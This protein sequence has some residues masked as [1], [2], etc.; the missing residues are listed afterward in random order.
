[1]EENNENDRVVVIESLQNEIKYLK[2][3]NETLL[4]NK[5]AELVSGQPEGPHSVDIS[6]SVSTVVS[7][8]ENKKLEELRAKAGIKKSFIDDKVK[9]LLKKIKSFKTPKDMSN[10][11]VRFAIKESRTWEK[12]FDDIVFEQQKYYEECVAFNDLEEAKEQVR[13]EIESLEDA[14]SDKVS[15]LNTE[16]E[17]RGLSCRA[18]NRS[19]D[20]VVFPAVFRGDLGDNVYKFVEEIK[21]AII[22]SQIKKSDQVKTLIKYLGGEAKKRCGDHYADLESALNAL[23]EFYGNAALIWMKTRNEFDNAFTNL[24]KEW[25]EYGDPA[26]VTA[27]ARVIE[28][29]RQS[30]YLAKEY[31]ELSAEIYSSSTLTLLRKVLP[32]DYIEKVNDT[33]SDVSASSEQKMSKIKEFL[34]KK[35]TSAL[36]GVDSLKNHKNQR[37]QPQQDSSKPAIRDPLGL[38]SQSAAI[39]SS[40]NI[41]HSCVKSRSCKQDWGLLGCSE[42]Y[43]LSTVDDRR[44][45]CREA[46]CCFR[47]GI[48][49]R[50]GDFVQSRQSRAKVP[51]RHRCDWSGDK[52]DTRCTAP[53]CFFGAATCIDHQGIPN[54]TRELLDWL[55]TLRIR[56]N[57]FAVPPVTLNGRKDRQ[58][59]QKQVNDCSNHGIISDSEVTRKLQQKLVIQD[60]CQE[61]VHPIP[62]GDG[63]FMFTLTPDI[64]GNP[65]Q[66]FMDTGANSFIMKTGVEKRLISVKIN[67]GPVSVS[68][69]G[70]L[71][72]SASG[73][74]G[75]LIPLADGSFQAVRGLCMDTVVGKLP[76]Y[77]LKPLLSQIKEENPDN[78]RLKQLNVP[79]VLGGHV[80]LLLGIKYLR[81]MPK[82]VHVLP[83]GLTIFESVIKPYNKGETAVIGG[84]IEAFESICNTIQAKTLMKHMVNLCSSLKSYK[85]SID[86]F[87][88]N[89]LETDDPLDKFTVGTLCS[90]Y[91]CHHQVSE[92]LSK[93]FSSNSAQSELQKF[94]KMQ[95]AGLDVSYRCR[96]CRT[97]QK[98]K[99]GDVEERLSLR[100]EAEQE[101]IRESITLDSNLGVATAKL[102]FIQDPDQKLIN[103]K[104]IAKKRLESI[105]NKYKNDKDIKKGIL[106]AWSKLVEKGHVKFV[107]DLSK[108]EKDLLNIGVSY[109]IPWNITHKDS[110]ST[111]IR[112]VFDASAATQSGNSLNSILAKGVPDLVK[113]LSLL[114]SWQMGRGACVA[115]ISQFYPTISLIPEHWR[116]Q[117]ILL[118]ENLH[119]DG[120]LIEAVITKLIF[121]VLSVSSLSEEVIRK[122]ALTIE[123]DHP[124]VSKFLTHYRYVDDLG[125]STETKDEAQAI[126]FKTSELLHDNLA[127]KIK[128]GW[129]FAGQDPPEEVSKDGI[130]VDFGGLA[131]CSKLDVFSL[132]IPP[133]YFGTKKRGK[134]PSTVQVFDG[135]SSLENF[136]PEEITRR[137]CT[138]IVAR[139]WDILGKVAP[140][141]LKLRHDLRKLIVS[142]PEWDTPLSKELRSY[143]INNFK[144]IDDTKDIMYLRCSIPSDAKRTSCR[145]LIKVDAAEVGIMIAAYS[146]YEKHDGTWSCNHLLGK[147]LLAPEHL[148]LAQKELQALSSGSDIYS[149]LS[150]TLGEWIEDI[151]VFSDSEI[152]LCWVSYETIKLHV[153]NRNRVVNITRQLNLDNLYHVQGKENCA[154]TGTRVKNV[155]ANSVKENSEWLLG[156]GWMRLSL[157]DAV[158]TGA[159]KPLRELKLSHENKKSVKEGIIFDSFAEDKDIFAVI[160]LAKINIEETAKREIEASYV[161]SPTNRKFPSFVRITALVL[162][163]A[164]L[165]KLKL[166]ASQVR[167]GKESRFSR[168]SF[169]VPAQ[170]FSLLSQSSSLMLPKLNSANTCEPSLEEISAALEYIFRIEAKLIK[171]FTTN[172]KVN[173]IAVEIEGVL[174]SKTRMEEAYEV[175]VLGGIQA[176]S[177]LKMLLGAN[178][179]VPLVE[180]HSPIVL[181]LIVYLHEHF[182]H[183]GVEST[184]K[185]SLELV[186]IIDGKSLFKTVSENCVKC[187]VK[188]KTLLKQIMGPL[189]KYQTSVTPVFFYCLVD[190]W[191][192]LQI[193]APGYQKSTRSSAAKQ[194]KAY[195]MIFVCAVTGMC[196]I[197]LIEGK[198]TSS[199]LDGCSRFFCEAT[200]PK[201]MLTDGDGAML[202]AFTRGEILLSDVAGNLYREKG[203]HF[204]VCSPQGHSAH[205]KV[206]RKIR[207]LQDSLN[208]SEIEH[209]RCTATGWIT[210][211][212]AIEHEANN[213]PIGYLYERS[214]IDGNPVLRMLRPNSLKGFG[215]TDRAPGGLFNIPNTPVDLMSKIQNLYDA[216]YKCWAASY[217]PMLLE[218]PK[219]KME[220]D[221]LQQN[222]VVYF[223]MT[224][225]PLGASWRL[226]KVE[227]VKVG[228]DGCVREVLIAYKIMEEDENSW[229][230]STVWRP[231]RECLKLFHVDD[232]TFM[233]D[234]REIRVKAE[235]ILFQKKEE[236]REVTEDD[237]VQSESYVQKKK[238]KKRSTELD[239]LK[240]PEFEENLPRLRSLKKVHGLFFSCSSISSWNA[241]GQGVS[242]ARDAL[243]DTEFKEENDYDKFDDIVFLL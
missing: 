86:H 68:V 38:R 22:D 103:N 180:K 237:V 231:V 45:Y 137:Q 162:K 123:K 25:G 93:V 157:A 95:E 221:N 227:D 141:T 211:A 7:R 238:K 220:Y 10:D 49:F 70:G 173:E 142:N 203:V 58:Q 201:V 235:E 23:K 182:N 39:S 29:L 158:K 83:C 55:Q 140:V 5:I 105:I 96:K 207:S 91:D 145:I 50:T 121:G 166:I 21:S 9:A 35:K 233:D 148:T 208:Q 186:K 77:R 52:P 146:S 78:Q 174:F 79:K 133:L 225:S 218:R 179:K 229:R 169:S 6:P 171:R 168:D 1:M 43:K 151:L 230:H 217:V 202:R 112:T 242:V 106:E 116:F 212:K 111:P 128:G 172:K 223:K 19:K 160:M 209:S 131:W 104:G 47:C 184:Y 115:D 100:Q 40:V 191:G 126:A 63:I 194:Y 181:P 102:P 30:D 57:L 122:F 3:N 124:Q 200:V 20:T 239:Q 76:Y 59:K 138:G 16:D 36:M 213:I 232:T 82:P 152:S 215:L 224:D 125:R 33:I 188:R 109:Y 196:N 164:K 222:D 216:W 154:D 236:S 81:I 241:A 64:N 31:T 92:N 243:Q 87:P 129:T 97:C 176:S 90:C 110:L 84:P 226:G 143:W 32:R 187:K 12:K 72:V 28:F 13:A 206:E 163:A 34:E 98:C 119:T 185:L 41:N 120:K 205:G 61:A 107:T 170:K 144:L 27:I 24:H 37:T 89:I 189:P 66:T 80:D 101:L 156:K 4:M 74:Y 147:G 240:L 56:H 54:A 155:S 48:P 234:M 26:R 198:D 53:S 94:L 175:E 149:M 71:E 136:T 60:G 14:I 165:F 8:D 177:D 51:V 183:K 210:V 167:N 117:R 69:A 150:S 159:I 204:E 99:G 192:P 113:L 11:E 44:K 2:R 15:L 67:P 219:W 199:I 153:F 228:K 127:M 178:F 46:N 132:R 193:Y 62:E 108:E 17:E 18:E 195:F 88:L 139:V 73:E 114:L 134:L 85:P 161:Y 75:A 130:T 214:S 197:Q 42:L 118:K 190:L 135:S 65:L